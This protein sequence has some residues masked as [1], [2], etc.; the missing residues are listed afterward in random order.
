MLKKDKVTWLLIS[1]FSVCKNI[2]PA[3]SPA[4]CPG[5]QEVYPDRSTS[6]PEH[7]VA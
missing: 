1:N 5:T 3:A 4:T 2:H 6:W 7:W